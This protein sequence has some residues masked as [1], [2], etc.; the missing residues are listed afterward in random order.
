MRDAVGRSVR[1]ASFLAVALHAGGGELAAQR[2]PA[3]VRTPSSQAVASAG[4]PIFAAGEEERTLDPL[5]G[6]VAGVVVGGGLGALAGGAAGYAIG[7]VLGG[8]DPYA[9]ASLALGGIG[10]A[11][12]YVVGGAIGA[13]RGV[14]EGDGAPALGVMLGMSL[15]GAVLGGVAGGMIARSVSGGGLLIGAGAAFAT[16]TII[17]SAAAC[18]LAPRCADRAA[19]RR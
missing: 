7:S 19:S 15:L 1:V 9:P 18:A 14:A 6:A 2:Q 3:P 11:A 17:T 13:R 12:G 5:G 8:D 16:H 10:A 4:S